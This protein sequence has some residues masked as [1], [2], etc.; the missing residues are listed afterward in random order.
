MNP[1]EEALK[2]IYANPE[3]R[4]VFWYDEGGVN[5]G[6]F[7]SVNLEGVEKL[8]IAGNEFGI[9]YKIL[10]EKPEG[11]FLVYSNKAKPEP[12][13][14]WL[15]DLYLSGASFSTDPALLV[16]SEMGFSDD[17]N[18]RRIMTDKL[19]PFFKSEPKKRE[20]KALYSAE[21]GVR[22]AEGGLVS[23]EGI[24]LVLISVLCKVKNH[25]KIEYVLHALLK[26][27]ADGKSDKIDELAKYGLE[28]ALWRRLAADFGYVNRTSPSVTDFANCLFHDAYYPAINDERYLLSHQALAFFN[29][30]KNGTKTRQV[31]LKLADESAGKLAIAADID[32]IE[33]GGFGSLD[34][35]REIDERII[36]GLVAE[37]E[38]GSARADDVAKIIGERKDGCRFAEFESEYLAIDAAA[39]FFAALSTT[40][41]TAIDASDAIAKYAGSWHR[42]D[43]YYRLFIEHYNVAR[44]ENDGAIDLFAALKAKVDG[45][46]VNNYL[47]PQSVDFQRQVNNLTSWTFDGLKRQ[48]NFWREYI[49]SSKASVC[50]IISDALRYEIAAELAEKI[51]S[52]HR[53]SAEIEPMVGVLPSYTQLGMA[54]LLPHSKL[55]FAGT[56][57]GMPTEWVLADGKSTKG[58]EAR[59]EIL[60]AAIPKGNAIA[61]K[62]LMSMSKPECRVFQSSASVLYVYHNAID[63]VG[64][65]RESE[66]ETPA[67]A[68]EA[69]DEIVALIKKVG[70]DYRVHNFIVT[71]DHGFLYQD[72]ELGPEQYVADEECLHNTLVDKSRF[73]IGNLLVASQKLANYKTQDLGLE[74]GADIRVA[75]GIMRMKHAGSGVKFVHGGA[76]LQEIVVPVV[77]IQHVRSGKEDIVPVDAEILVDGVGRITTNRFSISVYQTSP[78]GEEF[79]K[80]IVKLGLHAPDGRLLSDEVQFVLDSTAENVPDRTKSSMLTLNHVANAMRSGGVELWMETGKERSNGTYDWDKFKVKPMTLRLAI[81]NFFD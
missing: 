79:S 22:S 44:R 4:V 37:V 40:D 75:K 38:R 28:D 72:K 71:A 10:A 73:V 48:R 27:L 12:A 45:F 53:F 64:D 50:V 13:S 25:A 69:I 78:I 21:C 74:A 29:D 33:I 47:L 41:L 31:F 57:V 32:S 43:R 39:N 6:E 20:A 59:K 76:A 66:E 67:A 54:A 16:M 23:A 55:D 17:D 34:V 80:R 61:Y 9:K 18:I 42:I 1:I 11:K 77:K 52:T 30:W 19:L 8:V 70:G 81:Q 49:A 36:R 15:Y 7:D 14:D 24:E 35:Y 58:L 46:Y 60:E 3:K 2:R 68:R 26:E 65:K 56:D 5:R 51:E 63:A 62:D